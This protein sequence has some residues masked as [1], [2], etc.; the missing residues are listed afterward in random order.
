MARFSN[1]LCASRLS[2]ESG[3]PYGTILMVAGMKRLRKQMVLT[4]ILDG[5]AQII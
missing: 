2:A 3:S 1:M 5:S 4:I